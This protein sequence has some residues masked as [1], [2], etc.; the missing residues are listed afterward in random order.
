MTARKCVL[1]SQCKKVL[2][3]LCFQGVCEEWDAPQP[4]SCNY[5]NE[6]GVEEDQGKTRELGKNQWVE[7]KRIRG[8]KRLWGFVLFCLLAFI[9]LTW[10][11]LNLI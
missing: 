11:R 7:L 1:A 5:R 9:V 8:P 2:V 3:A 10:E 6:L 4:H